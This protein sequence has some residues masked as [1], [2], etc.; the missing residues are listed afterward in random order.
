MPERWF[1]AHPHTH[2]ALDDAI[3]QGHLFTNMRKE[4]LKD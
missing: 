1:S 3:E 4:N 2:S